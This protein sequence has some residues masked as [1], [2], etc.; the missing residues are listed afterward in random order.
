M[1]KISQP[2]KYGSMFCGRNL[3][4]GRLNLLSPYSVLK[5]EAAK[6]LETAVRSAVT[7]LKNVVLVRAVRASNL[8]ECNVP[9]LAPA[10]L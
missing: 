7:Y 2:L 1:E 3:P 9:I 6:L 4:T 10:E 8:T 5:M